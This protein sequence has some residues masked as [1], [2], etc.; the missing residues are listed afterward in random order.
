MMSESKEKGGRVK[1]IEYY[2][3]QTNY[4]VPFVHY[5][6]SFSQKIS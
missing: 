6:I 3:S 2:A 1:C 4:I 5:Y